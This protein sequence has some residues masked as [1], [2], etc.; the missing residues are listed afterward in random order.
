V[1]SYKA[2]AQIMG[3]GQDL[4]TNDLLVEPRDKEFQC[5]QI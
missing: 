2:T 3:F 4:V 1:R 5:G